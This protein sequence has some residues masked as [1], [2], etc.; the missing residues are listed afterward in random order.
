MSRWPNF[1][2]IGAGKSGTTSLYHYLKQH[3]Q[4]F[5]SPVKEPKYFA[6][7]GRDLNFTGP[8]DKRVIPQTANTVEAYLD[9]FK[10]VGDESII[11]EASTV[12]LNTGDTARKIA[13]QVPHAKLVAILRHP[14][15]RAYSAYMHLRRDG[16]EK[17]ETFSA[18]LDAEPQRISDGYYYHWHLRSRGYYGRQLKTFY[19][20]FQRSQIKVYLYEDFMESPRLMLSDIFQFLGV[21][22]S[23]KPDISARHNQSGIP[24][25]QSLQN[26]LTRSHPVKQ[27]AKRVIPERIGHRMISGMQRRVVSTPG[28]S[29]E[30]RAR[31]TE[32]YRSDI[33]ALQDL[34]RRDLSHWLSV[35]G[36]NFK[37]STFD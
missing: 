29:P 3:P 35:E 17:L 20:Q 10:D 37:Q 26:F 4:I 21:N 23:F 33:L 25:N 24:R 16:Y 13:E 22:E 6:L 14:A 9:L 12:Y 32:D 11:G 2:V 15:D 31:L 7:A 28:L 8:G 1:F 27:W 5:M 36:K 30:I 18:A 19:E 34:I